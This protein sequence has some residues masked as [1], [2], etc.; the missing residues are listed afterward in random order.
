MVSIAQVD[1]FFF[2]IFLY[3][4]IFFILLKMMLMLKENIKMIAIKIKLI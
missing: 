1:S 2:L 3:F 4:Y